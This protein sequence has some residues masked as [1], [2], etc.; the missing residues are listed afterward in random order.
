MKAIILCAGQGTRL[1][2]LTHTGAKHLVPVANKPVVHY[3]IEDLVQAGVNE[4]GVIVSPNVENA[5]KRDLQDG[6]KWGI[7]IEYIMQIEPKGLA[8]AAACA[9]EFVGEDRF[10]MTLGDNLLEQG[11]SNYVKEF[12]QGD[13]NAMILLYEVDDPSSFG[14]AKLEGNRI[15]QLIEKPKDPPSNLAIVG[16]YMFDHHIFEAIEKIEPSWR[17]EL[18]ITDAMQ[19]LI[20]DGFNV[21]PALVKGWW[22]DVG[23]P[24]DMLEA[25]RLLLEPLD[26]CIDGDVD[27]DTVIRGRVRV[28]KGAVVRNSELRGPLIIG[29]D[30]KIENSFIGPFSAI[31]EKCTVRDSEV[32]YSIIME[33]S[34]VEGVRRMD[35]SLV[36]RNVTVGYNTKPPKAYQLIL[37]DNSHIELI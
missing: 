23:Q 14:V 2:P 13:A 7:H 24:S 25:N 37:G 32:E 21:A 35:R 3:V 12:E 34:V 10:V 19:Q 31:G 4:I 28:E 29:P 16:V 26:T 9:R 1:R 30:A 17:G 22:R 15:V 33:D 27:K 18:E 11:A 5:F 6:S 20:D 36:G 8:H